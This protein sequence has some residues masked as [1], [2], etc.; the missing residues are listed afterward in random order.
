MF[1][2]KKQMKLCNVIMQIKTKITKKEY[3]IYK[4]L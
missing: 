4:D 1:K 3:K 2:Q